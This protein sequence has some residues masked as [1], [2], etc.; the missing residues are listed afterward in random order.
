MSMRET[1]RGSR[2]IVTSP[3]HLASAAGADV[4]KAGGTAVEAAVATAATLAVVYPHMTHIG[5]DG[6]WLVAEPGREPVGIDASGAAGAAVDD[7]LYARAGL[8]AVPTRGPLAANTVAGTVSGW[9][10]ALAIAAGWA[11]PLPLERL[12]EAAVW[13]ARNG[14]PVSRTQHDLTRDRMDELGAS[15][16]WT[17]TFLSD[18]AVPAVGSVLR[19]PALADTLERLA[20]AGLDDFYRGDL[21]R[22]MAR[23]LAAAGSPVSA[24]DLAG[25]RARYVRPLTVDLRCGRLFN[26]P[27]PTQGLASL[28]ILAAF[29]RLDVREAEGFDHV[30]GLVEATKQAFL[31][32]DAHV[33][34][35][36]VATVDPQSLL[37]DAAVTAA[38]T[39][40]DRSRAMAWPRPSEPGD[41]IWL[42]VIDGRGRS[43]SFIQSIFFEFGSGVVLPETGVLWQNRGSSFTLS[44]ASPRRLAPGRKPFHT[45]NPAMADLA[46]GRRMAYG[47]MGGEGQ[48]QTQAAVF[49]RFALFRQELQA[50]VTAPRWLLGKTWGEGSVGLKIEDRFDPA[51]VARL[52]AAG[53]AVERLEPF[54]SVMGHAGAV[55]REID[56]RLSGATDP[57]SDGAVSTF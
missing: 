34:C 54:T 42:G 10:A 6:F 56:G 49:T 31:V 25:H 4:L 36:T 3:H 12:F 48:P 18:G 39:G 35:P 9:Q 2:G 40:I 50:A 11:T 21:A 46:D 1:V 55:V 52:E 5:G 37:S 19:Q 15:P 57:R 45:L 23:D 41:T 30:H 29:D 24:E 43:V 53:H 38:A 47:C 51:L 14:Y 8:S 44:G 26:L 22:A 16:G 7:S 20:R 33:G 32:R 13:Y 17:G 28:L 27:P